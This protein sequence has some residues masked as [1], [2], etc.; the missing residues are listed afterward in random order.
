MLPLMTTLAECPS[1]FVIGRSSCRRWDSKGLRLRQ[2]NAKY[3]AKNEQHHRR[4]A[5]EDAKMESSETYA[6]L[7][8]AK[9]GEQRGL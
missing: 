2:E 4:N 6:M 5:F 8:P 7:F 9:N 1:T 3:G